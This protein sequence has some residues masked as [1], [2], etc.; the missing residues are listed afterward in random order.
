MRYVHMWSQYGV[1]VDEVVFRSW[2]SCTVCGGAFISAVLDCAFSVVCRK[3]SVSMF[4]GVY[5][6][7]SI[8]IIVVFLP[9]LTC[10]LS[11]ALGLIWD[12]GWMIVVGFLGIKAWRSG[13]VNS[14][15]CEF[16]RPLRFFLKCKRG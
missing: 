15:L 9:L 10:S 16:N 1:I 8:C 4:Y 13:V 11:L 5:A 12:H 14:R 2:Q 6:N 7:C 3:W